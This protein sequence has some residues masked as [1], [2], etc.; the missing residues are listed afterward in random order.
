MN[1][2]VT[3]T[4]ANIVFF[5]FAV[6]FIVFQFAA[7]F[8][9]GEDINKN[10]YETLIFSE[11]VLI[12]G[13]V[14]I[15]AL[16]KR[17]DLRETFRFHRLPI[18]PALV[19]V[20]ASFPAY[21]V[22]LLLNS[23]VY[24]V[25]QFIGDIPPSPIPIPQNLSEL[26]VGILIIAVTPAICEEMLHRGLLLRA[27]ERRGSMKAVVITSIFFGFFHFDI[28]NFFGPVFLGLIIG[29]YVVRTHSIFAGMLAH[30]LNNTIAEL[31]QYFNKDTAPQEGSTQMMT[32]GDL[33][34]VV[35]LGLGGLIA[36]GLLLKLFQYVTRT[37][38]VIL[39]SI[40][41][42]RKDIVSVLSHWP[43]I[44]T[45]ALYFLMMV[46]YLAS[47]IVMKAFAK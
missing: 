36:L 1:R 26:L 27:Y 23:L 9:F 22:A 40:S 34:Q 19:I 45:L 46:L 28:T 11:F 4:G 35:I 42:I 21:L 13:P 25:L 5:I 30:F 43:I 10:L 12:L 47:I 20:L 41:S 44:A 32:A 24:Y 38:A 8:I 14:L 33:G 6:V 17:V 39:P 2:R 29:Y 31:L 37:R 3:V 7:A 16:V 15:Y 18:V